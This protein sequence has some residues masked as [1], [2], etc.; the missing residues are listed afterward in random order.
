MVSELTYTTPQCQL[1]PGQSD[2]ELK[3]MQSQEVGNTSPT[4]SKLRRRGRRYF[5]TSRAYL[6]LFKRRLTYYDYRPVKAKL[7]AV[8][9]LV[10]KIVA[11]LLAAFALWIGAVVLYEIMLGW[12]M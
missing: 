1:K 8:A 2:V 9:L 4:D 11:A 10:S 7:Q 12:R 5:S 6:S 3:Q